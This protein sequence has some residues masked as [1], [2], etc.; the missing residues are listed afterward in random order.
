MIEKEVCSLELAKRLLD[1]GV[2]QESLFYWHNIDAVQ[3]VVFYDFQVERAGDFLISAYT[4]AELGRMLPFTITVYEWNKER[5]PNGKTFYLTA[6]LGYTKG[7]YS[8]SIAY[9]FSEF[10]DDDKYESNPLNHIVAIDF[11]DENEA[12]SRA[13]MLIWLIE[14]GYVPEKYNTNHGAGN[15]T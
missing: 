11:A 2:K 12:N 9:H 15:C 13:M 3:S 4:A 14:N 10:A 5:W 1:L 6:N 7:G 8:P